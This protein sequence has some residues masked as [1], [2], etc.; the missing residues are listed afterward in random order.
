MWAGNPIQ[1]QS[2][3]ELHSKEENTYSVPRKLCAWIL[4]VIEF[5]ISTLFHGPCDPFVSCWAH[6]KVVFLS[7]LSFTSLN[8]TKRFIEAELLLCVLS[9]FMSISGLLFNS[10]TVGMSCNTQGRG[11][12]L[13]RARQIFLLHGTFLASHHTEGTQKN[14]GK[15]LNSNPLL[16]LRE[17][18]SKHY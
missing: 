1:D 16:S 7:C 14:H 5:C 4:C 8:A 18:N 3:L 12:E 6:F 11:Q 15:E 17:T 9:P 2:S 10:V 13:K